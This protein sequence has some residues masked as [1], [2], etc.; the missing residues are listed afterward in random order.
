MNLRKTSALPGCTSGA[1]CYF[2]VENEWGDTGHDSCLL[3]CADYNYR[4]CHHQTGH[5]IEGDLWGNLAYCDD[6][7]SAAGRLQKTDKKE[8]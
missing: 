7:C 1:T 6:F 8:R 4:C 2:F 3:G 5:C